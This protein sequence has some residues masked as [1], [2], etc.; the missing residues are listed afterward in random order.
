MEAMRSRRV[1]EAANSFQ[2]VYDDVN[3]INFNGEIIF[4]LFKEFKFGGNIDFNSYSLKT[5]EHAWN[6]PLMKATLLAKYT[7]KKWSAG[8]DLFFS[9]DRKDELVNHS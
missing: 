2:V 3:T 6:L 5:E 7:R 9:S 8:A 4:D 1:I